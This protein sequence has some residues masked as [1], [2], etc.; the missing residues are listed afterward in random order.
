MKKHPKYFKYPKLF[1]K[2]KI[3]FTIVE[4]IIAITLIIIIWAISVMQY[5]EYLSWVRDTNRISQLNDLSK[6]M[7]IY[8][9]SK[10]LPDPENGVTITSTWWVVW[11]QW[12]AWK[13]VLNKVK[14][15]DWWIDPLDKSYFTYYLT[16]NKKYFQLMTFLEQKKDDSLN[17]NLRTYA[18]DEYKNRYPLV[19][20]DKI[21]I[22]IDSNNNPIQNTNSWTVNIS[23]ATWSYKS[24]LTNTQYITWNNTVINKIT[25]LSRTG[26]NW[27]NSSWSTDIK[28][29]V[30]SN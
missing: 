26:W 13:V 6:L 1:S 28:C 25:V 4:I 2:H 19:T 18:I 24:Y 14:F 15:K 22:M 29:R 30:S 23:T 17:L 8:R 11:I 3:A 10:K 21:W 20:W 5:T 9:V 16:A 7:S 27:C 12:F